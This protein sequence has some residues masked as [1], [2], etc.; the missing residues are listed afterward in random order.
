MS[1]VKFIH[2][3]YGTKGNAGLYLLQILKAYSGP[4]PVDAYVHSEFPRRVAHACVLRIFDHLSRFIPW[5]F[6]QQVY[7]CL[8]IYVCFAWLAMVI[9]LRPRKQRIFVFVQFFQS[10]HAYEWLFRR[11]NTHCTLIVTVHDAVELSHNYPALIM[12][13]R[14]DILRHAHFLLVHGAES[15][16]K[17]NY[18]SKPIFQI[19]FPLMTDEGTSNV[20]AY[21]ADG[22]VRFLFIGHIRIEKG[23]DALVDAWRELPKEILKNASLTIA[24]TYNGELN[25]DFD[26]LKNC[27]LIFDYLSDKRFVELINDSHYVVLPYRGGTNSGVL[28][29]AIAMNR[30]CITTRIPLFSESLFFE[31][32]LAVAELSSLSDLLASVVRNDLK[33][34]D[35]YL[36]QILI[37]RISSKSKFSKKINDFYNEIIR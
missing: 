1:P 26:S 18:L 9:I 32:R 20:P 16:K 15:V 37:N 21:K 33:D 35:I 13:S 23:I 4:I 28:S 6:A 27:E 30:P 36:K 29:V 31:E 25:I 11:I 3:D 8:D 10:F 5:K 17:L 7:K 22:I 14:D 34:Y 2:I 19:P 12:S 24:G